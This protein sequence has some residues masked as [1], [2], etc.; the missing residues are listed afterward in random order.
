MNVNMDCVVRD[1]S[2]IRSVCQLCGALENLMICGGCRSTWYCSKEHQRYDWKYHKKN[3]KTIKLKREMQSPSCCSSHAASDDNQN[4]AKC[5]RDN[6]SVLTQVEKE[7][8]AMTR[9]HSQIN[10]NNQIGSNSL[11]CEGTTSQSDDNKQDSHGGLQSQSQAMKTEQGSSESYI[12]ESNEAELEAPDYHSVTYTNRTGVEEEEDKDMGPLSTQD[13]RKTFFDVLKARNEVLGNY[14]V[15]CLNQYGI[16]VIDN[17]L[18]EGKGSSILS[19]VK[20]LHSKDVFTEGQLV[21]KKSGS[22]SGNIRGDM[23]TWVDGHEKDCEDIKFLISSMDAVI[24]QCAGKLANCSINGRTKAMVA[25]YPGKESGYVRHVDNPNKDGRCVTCI[26]YLNKGWDPQIDGGVLRIFPEGGSTIAC[27]EP[28][29]DRL[30]FFWSDRRN[31]HEVM[32]TRKTRYAITVWY[33][34]AEERKQA[35]K[36]F[37][38]ELSKSANANDDSWR[39]ASCG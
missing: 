15:E 20:A 18:G 11:E 29:F 34:D 4:E 22:V 1:K 36:R 27:I 2:N 3:C 30:L 8:K 13:T 16:C 38:E 37:R 25:C 5:V 28:K 32:P 14:V 17:F 6:N 7:S 39:I 9:D 10:V 26:Y 12:L 33:Y 19:E 35:V 21:N 23:I 24:L 31:P